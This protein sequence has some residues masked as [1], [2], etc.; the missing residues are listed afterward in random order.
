M[1]LVP[2]IKFLGHGFRKLEQEQDRQT[3]RYNRAHYHAACKDGKVQKFI[4]SFLANRNQ[5][6]TVGGKISG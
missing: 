6:V 2:K 5:R 4:S 3:D 1:Y